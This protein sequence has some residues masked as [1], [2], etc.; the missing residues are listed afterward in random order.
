MRH[1]R[2]IK[3]EMRVYKLDNCPAEISEAR[4]HNFSVAKVHVFM[5]I[6]TMI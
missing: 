3:F 5:N 6:L 4:R 1:F 2:N